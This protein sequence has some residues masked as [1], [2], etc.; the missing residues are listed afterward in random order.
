MPVR[1]RTQ[2]SARLAAQHVGAKRLATPSQAL[3]TIAYTDRLSRSAPYA[4]PPKHC[5]ALI[6]KRRGKRARL[7]RDRAISTLIFDERE[8]E[9]LA[10]H[11]VIVRVAAA[12]WT[13][14]DMESAARRLKRAVLVVP[15]DVNP[16]S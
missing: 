14:G 9:L 2:A 7:F 13:A 4:D 6:L 8:M 5:S 16:S 11:S 12:F 3:S 1:R 10:H 15:A